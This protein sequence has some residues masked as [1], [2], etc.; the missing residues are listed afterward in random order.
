MHIVLWFELLKKQLK[1][2]K[3]HACH[4]G[5]STPKESFPCYYRV[6]HIRCGHR[7][8]PNLIHPSKAVLINILFRPTSYQSRGGL[9]G[10]GQVWIPKIE[11]VYFRYNTEWIGTQ[12]PKSLHIT[13][14]VSVRDNWQLCH[15]FFGRTCT[16][17]HNRT[18]TWYHS[19]R[20]IYM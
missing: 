9:I 1:L 13:L 8:H 11:F 14:A 10:F 19:Y 3:V 7:S 5:T 17:P 16:F 2:S 4:R 15:V 12:R 20:I 6:T 18:L